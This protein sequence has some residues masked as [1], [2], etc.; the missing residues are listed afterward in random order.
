MRFV[1]FLLSLITALNLVAPLTAGPLIGFGQGSIDWLPPVVLG[2]GRCI[3]SD[4]SQ[5]LIL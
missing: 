2:E 4:Q 5:P 3:L 1:F